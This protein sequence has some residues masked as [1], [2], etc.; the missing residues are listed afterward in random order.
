MTKCV[1]ADPSELLQRSCLPGVVE[2]QHQDAEL[3]AVFLEVPE[4]REQPLHITSAI[5]VDGGAAL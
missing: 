3:F 4:E 5:R 1:S 2:S